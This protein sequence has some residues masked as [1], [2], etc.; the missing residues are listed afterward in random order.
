MAIV[1]AGPGGLAAA[2]ILAA[3]GLRVTVFERRETVGGRTSRVE[4]TGDNGA[5]YR[6]DRG[7]T[8]FLMP[9][10][11]DEVFAAAGER[12]SDH[13]ELKRLDPMYRLIIGREGREALTINA[14]QDIAEMSRRIGAI[15]ERDGAAFERFIANQ[16][17]KL[18]LS[19]PILRNPM[20]SLLDLANLD[21]LKVAP[22]LKPHK[23]VHQLL[24]EYF[25]DEHVKLAV[26]FQSKYLGMSPFEC[27]SLFTILPL[28][29]YEYG[30]WHPIGGCHALCEAMATV[31]ERSGAEV[32]LNAPVAGVTFDGRR[33]KG[34]VVDGEEQ[35]FDAVVVNADATWALK[36]LVPAELRADRAGKGYAD[37]ALDAK[38]YSCSTYMLYLGVEGAVDLPHHTIHTSPSYAENLRDITERARLSD[39]P[40]IY[41]CN[42]SVTDPTLAP[43]GHSS[44]YVL[45]PTP[46]TREGAGGGSV[47][48]DAEAPGLRERAYGQ[49][50]RVF[51]LWDIRERVRAEV[52]ITPADW[53]AMGINH[54]A[55]FN[56]AHNLRQ[57]L[58]WRPQNRLKGFD[59]LY[60]V[61]G[62][63]HP[64]SGLPTIFLSSQISSRLLCEDLGCVVALDRVGGREAMANQ[65]AA[66][67]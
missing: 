29:E 30:V 9:Y 27:P 45:V 13:V 42:P 10:V 25:S 63:T 62:G 8:F 19:E 6:F 53:R 32:R 33:A 47:D 44:V 60:L 16:R 3:S 48:W 41:V 2:V 55:T 39:D 4:T 18:R 23:T 5:A 52:Q 50:E 24:G 67:V 14:T 59:G 54:G 36:N 46:N 57:M 31:A 21:S 65:T 34:V 43:E 49:L 20:R 15:N 28:I 66:S 37:A 26:S 38:R 61:G 11:L 51:G 35:L 40:S 64:G 22:M 17:T 58:H 7:A 56:L 1:G 12:V